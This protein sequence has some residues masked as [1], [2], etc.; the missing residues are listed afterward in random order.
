MRTPRFGFL[1]RSIESA[2]LLI[3]LFLLSACQT[4]S[5]QTTAPLNTKFTF[6]GNV[7][8]KN[9]EA[10]KPSASAHAPSNAYR[11]KGMGFSVEP[12]T[13]LRPEAQ[14]FTVNVEIKGLGSVTPLAPLTQQDQLKTSGF[15][16]AT[17]STD[18]FH[19]GTPTPIKVHMNASGDYSFTFDLGTDFT[20]SEG[21]T[22]E[23]IALTADLQAE[24]FFKCI[25]FAV[26]RYLYDCNMYACGKG[27]FNINCP[28]DCWATHVIFS[29]D[30]IACLYKGTRIYSDLSVK[31]EAQ[32]GAEYTVPIEFYDFKT[33]PGFDEAFQKAMNGG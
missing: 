17:L 13:I 2:S 14:D 15:N 29:Y 26:S 18:H 23:S 24:D 5:S 11:Y 4:D 27:G 22:V 3:P 8:Y 12:G 9:L 1:V 20:F 32:L 10:Q 31:P 7:T 30:Y 6:S 21:A 25:P 28:P 33:G 16:C 19:C